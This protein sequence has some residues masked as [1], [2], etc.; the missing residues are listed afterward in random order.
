MRPAGGTLPLGGAEAVLR[1][2]LG[3]ARARTLALVASVGSE[4]DLDRVHSPLLSPLAWDLGHIAAFEDLWVCRTSGLEPLRPGLMGVYDAAETPRAARGDLPY[5]R[6]RE[7]LAFME[8]VRARTLAALEADGGE[9]LV[10]EMLIQHEQQHNETMLQTLQIA[11]AGTFAPVRR[12]LPPGAALEGSVPVPGGPF[13]MGS[14]DP[15]FVYDNER[16][17]HEVDV[18]AFRIDLTPVTCGAFLDWIEHGGYARR[19]WWSGE[20]WTWLQTEGAERPLFWTEANELRSFERVEAIDPAQ[21]VMNVS[22]FEADAYARAHGKRLPT[23]AEWE[24][25]ASDAPLGNLDVDGFGPAQVGAY[26]AAPS[27][28]FGLIGDVWEW[29]ATEF[30]GYP[31][32]RAHPYAEYSEVFFGDGYR[33]LRGGSWAT[34][35]SVARATFRNWD[36]PERRQIFAGFRCAEDA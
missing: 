32:F 18:P 11:P 23:E 17:A 1:E 24:K 25:A 16:P 27:G 4:A 14:D 29:T 13:R 10:W 7:A 6:H 3:E 5:L 26:P 20:G 28:A 15:G 33:V 21:P 35:R 36:R 31:G 30:G 12:G 2:R 9:N 8:A 22:W 34:S 19:E